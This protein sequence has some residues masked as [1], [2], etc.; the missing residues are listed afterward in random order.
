MLT[1]TR[2]CEGLMCVENTSDVI[3]WLCDTNPLHTNR[4]LGSRWTLH[5]RFYRAP[6]TKSD[7]SCMT[8][9]I[10]F[11]YVPAIGRIFLDI[12]RKGLTEAQFHQRIQAVHAAKNA[13]RKCHAWQLA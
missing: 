10:C 11:I 7:F 8:R 5:N 2:V 6:L 13:V 3:R 1:T 4:S 12:R 9:F